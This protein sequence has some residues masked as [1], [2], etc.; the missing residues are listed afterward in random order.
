[1]RRKHF[2]IVISILF[3]MMTPLHGLADEQNK[4]SDQAEEAIK[5][6]MDDMT[7]E[8]KIGQLFI[9]HV[10][11]ETP[12][13][14]NYEDTN[15]NNNRGGKNFKEVIENYHVGGIIYFNWTDNIG[16]PVDTEQV[17]ELSNGLQEIAEAQRAEI[18]LFRSEEHTSELA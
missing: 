3:I 10:Y 14:P 2:L 17:N 6:M 18:P 15:L 13:D 4:V 16:T 9:V 7:L 8:E 11:G 5:D 1:M 12:T